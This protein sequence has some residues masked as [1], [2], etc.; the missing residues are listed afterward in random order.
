MK[1]I[2]RKAV[3]LLLALA[4]LFGIALPSRTAQAAFGHY[5]SEA[6]IKANLDAIP[7]IDWT[8]SG[9]LE[10]DNSIRVYEWNSS[11][12]GGDFLW[13]ISQIYT[14]CLPAGTWVSPSGASVDYAFLATS[15]ATAGKT[16]TGTAFEKWTSMNV[17][18][19][20]KDASG[21][22]I[23]CFDILASE[24]GKRG[25]VTME[26]LK[27]KGVNTTL[28]EK[29][30]GMAQKLTENNFKYLRDNAASFFVDWTSTNPD[31]PGFVVPA[32]TVGSVFAKA[33]NDTLQSFVQAMIWYVMN[34]LTVD[35]TRQI[36]WYYI[37]GGT[38][39]IAKGGE[40]VAVEASY[41]S[42]GAPGINWGVPKGINQPLTPGDMT[43]GG[44]GEAP[45]NSKDGQLLVKTT[46]EPQLQIVYDPIGI[47]LKKTDAST[48]D[49]VRPVVL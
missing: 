18:H 34:D 48:A 12:G 38:T 32:S 39:Y 19:I 47:L 31:Y 4:M 26:Q 42:T 44:P 40:M 16:I 27:T 43:W 23:Y 41:S 2:F 36:D 21:N 45:Q 5:L 17:P 6:E 49:D 10:G 9:R 3:V 22:P 35:T 20:W 46:F 30:Y 28:L 25:P 1:N 7:K 8:A 14:A 13:L 29:V 15:P 11:V 37:E 24:L 33:S